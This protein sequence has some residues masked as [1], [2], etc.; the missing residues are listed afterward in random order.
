MNTNV[1]YLH[2]STDGGK[3]WYDEEDTVSNRDDICRLSCS[4]I[5]QVKFDNGERYDVEFGKAILVYKGRS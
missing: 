5:V 1:K 2:I 4:A 3:T